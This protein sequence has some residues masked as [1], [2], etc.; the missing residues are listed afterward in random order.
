MVA[1]KRDFRLTRKF[2]TSLNPLER[3]NVL[4]ITPALKGRFTAKINEL[5]PCVALFWYGQLVKV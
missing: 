1:L 4:Y 2:H 3:L 5:F